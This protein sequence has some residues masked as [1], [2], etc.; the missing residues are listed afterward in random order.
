M[1]GGPE[2][3]HVVERENAGYIAQ[4][5]CRRETVQ[6][7]EKHALDQSFHCCFCLPGPGPEQVPQTAPELPQKVS[8][9]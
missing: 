4:W 9:R 5:D 6:Q 3:D 8:G 2:G 7:E 1:V